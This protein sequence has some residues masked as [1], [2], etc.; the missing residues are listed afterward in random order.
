MRAKPRAPRSSSW[1]VHRTSIIYT[2]EDQK[3]HGEAVSM[4]I[5]AVRV[6]PSSSAVAILLRSHWGAPSSPLTSR[7]V[8][9]PSSFAF[10]QLAVP[11][12]FFTFTSPSSLPSPPST[13]LNPLHTHTATANKSAQCGCSSP[14]YSGCSLLP[15]V[16]LLWVSCLPSSSP[17]AIFAHKSSA[18]SPATTC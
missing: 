13:L 4:T 2:K 12:L 8:S 9:L 16:A 1:K 6:A 5:S 10:Y 11:Q 14:P 7:L 3:R 15:R 18:S 17:R